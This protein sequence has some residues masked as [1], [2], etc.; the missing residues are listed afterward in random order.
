MEKWLFHQEALQEYLLICCQHPLGGLL[1]K[2]GKPR[3]FYHTCYGLSG[4]S[5]AQHVGGSHL[6]STSVVGSPLNELAPTHPV[7]NIGLTAVVAALSYFNQQPTFNP[8]DL[9]SAS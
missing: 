2:P 9:I 8:S 5:V 1:D 7:Y 3:D 6:G 4:L